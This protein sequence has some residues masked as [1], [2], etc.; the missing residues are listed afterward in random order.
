MFGLLLLSL[1]GS[2]I[3]G[4][5]GGLKKVEDLTEGLCSSKPHPVLISST[6]SLTTLML[7]DRQH[8]RLM[9]SEV[10]QQGN[11]LKD[12]LEQLGM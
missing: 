2:L 10:V 3:V 12:S 9:E 4:I 11:V 5:A 1:G 7:N 8:R 6:G